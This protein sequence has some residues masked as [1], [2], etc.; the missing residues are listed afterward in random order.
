MPKSSFNV[1]LDV[2]NATFLSKDVAML[3]TK[4]GELLL[5]TLVYDGRY[6]NVL[7]MITLFLLPLL[8]FFFSIC[9]F[10]TL[11]AEFYAFLESKRPILYVSEIYE[12]FYGFPNS[13]RSVWHQLSI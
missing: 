6:V 13:G 10:Y 11:W 4:A 5:L 8:S 2:A 7:I 3:S 9:L 1:E 12:L